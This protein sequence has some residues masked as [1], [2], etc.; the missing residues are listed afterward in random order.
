[1]TARAKRR[2]ALKG[3][4]PL[5]PIPRINA[6]LEVITKASCVIDR[7]LIQI[8][9]FELRTLTPQDV[10]RA[11]SLAEYL[12]F[13][14]LWIHRSATRAQQMVTTSRDLLGA[15]PAPTTQ[16]P[17]QGLRVLVGGRA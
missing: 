14:P 8:E 7:E 10:R 13:V 15:V 3:G 17:R 12:S 5:R 9:Q 4:G 16:P 6:R 1:M 11:A 2:A